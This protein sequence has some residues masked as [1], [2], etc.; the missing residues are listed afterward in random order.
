[1]GPRTASSFHE[2]VVVAMRGEIQEQGALLGLFEEQ[3]RAIIQR[4]SVKVMSL[5][6]VIQRQVEVAQMARSRREV[7]M[8]QALKRARISPQTPLMALIPQ[9]PTALQPLMR[10]LVEEVIRIAD[11]VRAKANQNQ[12]LL[13]RSIELI[14]ELLEEVSPQPGGRIYDEGGSVKM[15]LSGTGKAYIT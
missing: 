3:Q 11:R 8:A 12:V 10:A 5:V 2:Q 7:L 9:F 1:M 4:D 13:A 14:R 15:K 6:T